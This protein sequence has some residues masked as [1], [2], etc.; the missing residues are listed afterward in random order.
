LD[1]VKLLK[2]VAEKNPNAIG[3][4][5]VTGVYDHFM[6]KG[7]NG[8]HVCMTFEVLGENL[9]ALIKRYKHRGIPSHLVKQIAKQMLYGLDYLHRECHIIHTDLKPENVLMC[10]DNAEEL[11]RKS[12]AQA[13]ATIE[14]DRMDDHVKERPRSNNHHNRSR[15]GL[16]R[17]RSL[18][19]H[20]RVQMIASQ[21]L[22][23]DT[24]S[25]DSI[26]RRG[27]PPRATTSS[28]HREQ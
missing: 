9:L 27:R 14:P 10:I 5:H 22:S 6:H 16:S 28:H 3:R 15:D 8:T 26:D 23:S 20:D 24:E 12:A 17:G 18:H 25:R 21:P 4:Q 1:E 7:T 19:R 13:A 2:T 11:V